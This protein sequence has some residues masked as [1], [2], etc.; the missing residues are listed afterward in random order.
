[1]S[2]NGFK[3]VQMIHSVIERLE[4][5][6]HHTKEHIGY[7]SPS[8]GAL[9]TNLTPYL[10]GL[11]GPFHYV[12]TSYTPNSDKRLTDSNN[13]GITRISKKVD[14]DGSHIYFTTALPN[15]KE[16]PMPNVQNS[17]TLAVHMKRISHSTSNDNH[18]PGYGY[19]TDLSMRDATAYLAIPEIINLVRNVAIA[20]LKDV[21]FFLSVYGM[22]ATGVLSFSYNQGRKGTVIEDRNPV[23]ISLD[24]I[25][26]LNEKLDELQ[27]AY[28][29][30]MKDLLENES[31]ETN[32]EIIN[33]SIQSKSRKS[34]QPVLPSLA[35]HIQFTS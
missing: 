8:I 17:N 13:M 34:N 2:Y 20:R 26:K 28:L 35:L 4:P 7:Q 29:A 19:S 6:L 32:T 31:V 30:K 22:Y 11:K 15:D 12:N 3:A 5:P 24:T 16:N 23:V 33:Q 21:L 10:V 18:L 25:D 14:F 9:N 1:M 27:K